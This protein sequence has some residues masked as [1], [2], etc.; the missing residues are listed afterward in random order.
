[1]QIVSSGPDRDVEPI[2]KLYF[3]AIATAREF[4]RRGL[5]I[6]PSSGLNIAAARL[7]AARLGPGHH[8][9]TVLPDR[10]ERYFSTE[11]IQHKS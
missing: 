7:L 1:M 5:G 6:G 9:G 10:M 3:A 11:L 4:G 2:Q 8:V